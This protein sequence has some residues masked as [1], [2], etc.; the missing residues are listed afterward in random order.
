MNKLTIEQIEIIEKSLKLKKIQEYEIYF[1]DQKIY[2]T[3]FL[4]NAIESE[5][6]VRD[7][8][9]VIRILTQKGDET[10]IGIIKGNSLNSKEIEKNIDYCL[11]LSKNNKGSKYIFPESKNISQIKTA[12]QSIIKDPINFKADIC[13][14]IKKEID[15][16]KEVTPTFGRFRIHI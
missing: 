6:D 12:D 3:E 10:G 11:I 16:H 4:K 15:D 1:V 14:Q 7:I 13:D 5:R 2:E 8:E 9:Y